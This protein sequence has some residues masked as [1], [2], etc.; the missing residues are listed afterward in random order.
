MTPNVENVKEEIQHQVYLMENSTFF[1][2][3]SAASE[4]KSLNTDDKKNLLKH[5]NLGTI[6]S[7][8]YIQSF[9]SS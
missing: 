3:Y 7:A 4:I 9:S 2:L 6:L 8:Q 1:L 5:Y